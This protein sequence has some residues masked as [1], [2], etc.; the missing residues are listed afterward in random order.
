MSHEMLMAISSGYVDDEWRGLVE[1]KAGVS[2]IAPELL[3]RPGY[4]E[5][6]DPC[7]TVRGTDASRAEYRVLGPDGRMHAYE[8]ASGLN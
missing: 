4:E 8:P 5:F 3:E 7:V 6:F 1:I 2:R